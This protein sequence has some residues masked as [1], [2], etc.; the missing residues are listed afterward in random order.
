MTERVA[1]E[2]LLMPTS[3][4]HPSKKKE[5]PSIEKKDKKALESTSKPVIEK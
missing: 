1:P 4:E 3:E 2:K 5:Q